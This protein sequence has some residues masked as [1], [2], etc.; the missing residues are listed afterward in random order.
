[1]NPYTSPQLEWV[2]LAPAPLWPE[3]AR[4]QLRLPAYGLL[5]SGAVGGVLAVAAMLAALI[6]PTEAE[7]ALFSP[8]V[9][10]SMTLVAGM[11]LVVVQVGIARG[12]WAL[13]KLQDYREARR[14][15]LLAVISLGG[16]FFIGFPFGLWALLRLIDGRAR[17]AFAA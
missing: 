15:V 10:R 6:A 14:G 11:L 3:E 12:G 17:G 8:L 13:L 16:A 1:M 2:D 4:E 5:V 7:R 9:D